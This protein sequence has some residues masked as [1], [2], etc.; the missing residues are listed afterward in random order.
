ME[1]RREGGCSR[2]SASPSLTGIYRWLRVLR[3]RLI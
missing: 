1:Q 3:S 2:V